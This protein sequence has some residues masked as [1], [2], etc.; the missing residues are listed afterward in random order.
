MSLVRIIVALA[1][2]GLVSSGAS[3]QA[4]PSRVASDPS[5]VQKQELVRVQTSINFHLSGPTGDSDEAQ[6]LRE[7]ARRIVYE[8]AARECDLAREVF[9]RDCRLES[10][11]NNIQSI[12]Q[13]GPQQQEGYNITGSMTLQVTLK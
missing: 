11:N 9:A 12:R 8:M 4:P 7:R 2:A 3:A 10:I 13:Y 1:V 5:A 6:K